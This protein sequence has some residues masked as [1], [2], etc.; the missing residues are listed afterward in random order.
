MHPPLTVLNR[1]CTEKFELPSQ[2]EQ[3]PVLE[4]GKS[5]TIPVYSIHRDP[6]Y[7]SSPKEFKPERFDEEFGG[8]KAFKDRGVY[9]AFGDGPRICLG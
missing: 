2:N 3:K 9:Y 8:I 1:I 5:V 7:Y 4:V 6:E